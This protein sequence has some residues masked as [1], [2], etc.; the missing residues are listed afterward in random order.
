MTKGQYF[1]VRLELAWF[2]SSLLYGTQVMLV[3]FFF[4]THFWSVTTSLKTNV[5]NLNQ[6]NINRTSSTICN[7]IWQK[8]QQLESVEIQ[9]RISVNLGIFKISIKKSQSLLIKK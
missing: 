9:K 2:V 3:C 7:E 5:L 4:K 8:S 1:P 6:L